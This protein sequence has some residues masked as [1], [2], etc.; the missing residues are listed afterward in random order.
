MV[1]VFSLFS[2]LIFLP[3]LRLSYRC[4]NQSLESNMQTPVIVG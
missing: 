4:L 1:L 3:A 2:T